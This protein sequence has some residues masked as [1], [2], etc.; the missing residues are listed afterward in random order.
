[1]GLVQFARCI[2]QSCLQLSRARV[3]LEVIACSVFSGHWALK[4]NEAWMRLAK[5]S[6]PFFSP[7]FRRPV[8]AAQGILMCQMTSTPVIHVKNMRRTTLAKCALT[9]FGREAS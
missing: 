7:N 8:V 9:P 6:V 1:M 2:M 4:L 5:N 3:A